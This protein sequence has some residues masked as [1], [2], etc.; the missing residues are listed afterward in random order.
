MTIDGGGKEYQ[1]AIINESYEAVL[2]AI[3]ALA[4][5]ALQVRNRQQEILVKESGKD[6]DFAKLRRIIGELIDSID[7][8]LT[9][10]KN[11]PQYAY[12]WG[13]PLT[14]ITEASSISDYRAYE[15]AK[16]VIECT[17]PDEGDV[18]L[19][20]NNINILSSTDFGYALHLGVIASIINRLNEKQVIN[21]NRRIHDIPELLL[22]V[23]D[24]SHDMLFESTVLEAL[25][26]VSKIV[27]ALLNP[28]S[29][30]YENATRKPQEELL[31]VL[32]DLVRDLSSLVG[33]CIEE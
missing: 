10:S 6:I 13:L 29:D 32:R 8:F 28:L 3:K 33:F 15:L 26:M 4:Y 2:C 20:N 23:R 30:K 25:S 27:P 22:V 11:A 7:S 24:Y 14:V 5:T 9:R 31:C 21:I 17:L 12:T 18:L 16:K 1:Q 19:K